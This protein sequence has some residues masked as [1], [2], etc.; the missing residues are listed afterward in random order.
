[1]KLLDDEV[2]VCFASNISVDRGLQLLAEAEIPKC[3]YIAPGCLEALVIPR[4][5][6]GEAEREAALA[7]G[8][9]LASAKGP[10][11][12]KP[13]SYLI[14][15][16]RGEDVD[17]PEQGLA[18]IPVEPFKQRTMNQRILETSEVVD[19]MNWDSDAHEWPPV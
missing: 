2:R 17:L 3:R 15:A 6:D 19:P 13:G 12:E 8:K 9:D 1:M 11:A 10:N 18:G 5:E 14:L 16:T 4:A 7:F